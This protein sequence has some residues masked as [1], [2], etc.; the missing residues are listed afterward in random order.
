MVSLSI[1]SLC[2]L[3]CLRLS[4]YSNEIHEFEEKIHISNF[5]VFVGSISSASDLALKLSI[6]VQYSLSL[7]NKKMV[8]HNQRQ[9]DRLPYLYLFLVL[10]STSGDTETNPGPEILNNTSHFPC[11]VCDSSVGWDDRGIVC[12]TCNTWFHVDCQGMS[13][14]MYSLFNRSGNQSAAWECCQCGMPNLS[15]S[16]FDSYANIST[17]NRFDSLS[18]SVSEP[19]SPLP[20]FLGSPTAASSPINR[21]RVKPI[22]R[23]ATLNHPL[24]LLLINCQSIKNKK[25]EFQTI[26]ETAKPDI[27]FGNESWL[28]PE[29]S[30]IEIFPEDYDA[31]RKDRVGDAHGGVF[32]AFRKDLLCVETPE[33]ITGS[34]M[35]WAKLEVVGCK[36][37]HLCS[38]YRPPDKVDPQYLENL[39][40]SLKR[41]MKNKNAQVLV[42]G[43]FNCGDIDWA[44]MHVPPGVQKSQTQKQLVDIALEH[45]L[46]QVVDIPT[47]QD[48]TL[49]I[50][51]TNN[52]T[53]VNRIRGMPPIGKADHDIV[54]VEYD[55]KAKRLRQNPRKIFIYKRG[56]MEGLR[57]HMSN[58][59]ETFHSRNLDETN[60]NDMWTE[61]KNVLLTAIDKHIPSKMTKDKVGYP[62]IDRRIK[63]LIS[64]REKLYHRARKSSDPAV[65][66]H[67][68]KFRA[69]VQKAIR[70]AY[71]H[72]VSDIFTLDD[73]DANQPRN[74]KPKKFWSF[75]NSL[76]KD[77]LGIASLRQNGVLKTSSKDKANI[78]NDQFQSV[79]T[80]ESNDAITAKDSSPYSPM[81]DITVHPDGVTKLLS[82]LNIHKAQGP[83]NLNA[84]VLKECRVEISAILTTIYNQSI[85]QGV[86]PEDW[87]CAN[88]APVFKKGEKYNPANYRP[89]SLTCICCK[90]LEHI[91]VSNIMKHLSGQNILA[92]SQ[93]G[94]RSH[95]SCETQLVQFVH[96]ILQNLD[97]CK[98]IQK[99]TDIIIMDFAKA[100]DK[101][102]HRRLSHKLDY[103]G[104][105]GST[106]RWISAWLNGR[107]QQVVLDG[108]SS[109]C[110]NVLSGVPQ[111]S[112]LGPVLF[113]LFIND[114]PD[115]IRS[116][117]RLFAD[118]C[119]L[120]RNIYSQ[121]D[122]DILQN[123]L[124]KLAL[125]EQDWLMEF[126]VSKCHTLRVSRHRTDR[127]LTFDYSLHD[128]ILETVS[129]AKYLGVTLNSDL[130]WG[131]HIN[132][133][134]SKANKTLGFLRRNLAFAPRETKAMAYKTLVRPQ[135]EYASAVWNPYQQK[136]IDQVEKV[137]RTAAR[138]SC[139]RW[140]NCSHVGEMLDQLEWP[141]LATRRENASLSFFYKIHSG[142]AIIDKDQ[143]LT[144]YIPLRGM[145]S[146]HDQQYC[147]PNV[148]TDALKFSFFPRTIPVWNSLPLSA[149]SCKTVEGFKT[150]I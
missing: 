26:I 9:K 11:G 44:N 112:V 43:D 40:E 63:K 110:G 146:S 83:D 23:K 41:I 68:K 93:H 79:F 3:I 7:I 125:W 96:D 10:V 38:F 120:Y 139:R 100:F 46:T 1:V 22:K 18:G 17:S 89:V 101:V 74:D 70:D 20:T 67:F 81:E 48:R 4:R 33:L 52:P 99:Q 141:T 15:T 32:L 5:P 86:V 84:R 106:N 78:L 45:C 94:F 30:N 29:I 113:L 42:G 118:D 13:P 88:V 145:R 87:R 71:W 66:D 24:R 69:V 21:P 132:N 122:A 56:D 95:R 16:L 2:L 64:K 126:N 97:S 114:L 138:W 51:L 75:I 54:Y 115:G 133:I 37:L 136:Y 137:Q 128:Q 147:R 98:R 92:D 47:R 28:S 116:S 134:S 91:L 102:P 144:R 50:L 142:D 60:V 39:N 31:I 35:T 124:N 12:D 57:S 103:Y 123:D 8:G 55:I 65:R 19:D 59:S 80:R 131:T 107:T 73:D 58:F 61:F 82:K 85:I 148:N 135:L 143:Y 129:S 49:D 149:V 127:Q 117:V 121:D 72:Y 62:W 119:V 108:V 130:D 77:N 90:T 36:T 14:A 76:K 150:Q 105:G 6:P 34:E 53:P 109:D 27:V 25:A 104:V 111:G 140:R